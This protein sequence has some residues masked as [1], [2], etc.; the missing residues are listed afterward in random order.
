MNGI[1]YKANF[2][3][4]LP[5]IKGSID[6]PHN[7]S[8]ENTIKSETDRDCGAKSGKKR[9]LNKFHIDIEIRNM[10]ESFHR[11]HRD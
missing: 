7:V 5:D 8:E 2:S 9:Y 11:H 4:N 10:T 3:I 6:G 1:Q